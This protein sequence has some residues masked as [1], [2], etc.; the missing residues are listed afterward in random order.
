LVASKNEQWKDYKITIY[1]LVLRRTAAL[2]QAGGDVQCMRTAL[3]AK[4]YCRN[5]SKM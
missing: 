1:S 2:Q 5:P 3:R 4:Q